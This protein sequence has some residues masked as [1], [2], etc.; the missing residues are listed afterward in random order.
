MAYDLDYWPSCDDFSRESLLRGILAIC[1]KVA[2]LG[3]FRGRD[4]IPCNVNYL[5][6][7]VSQVLRFLSAKIAS[8]SDSLPGRVGMELEL[9]VAIARCRTLQIGQTLLMAVA[10]MK[11]A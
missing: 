11:G 3:L 9:V 10:N 4:T 5:S 2:S 8:C 7:L 1:S 6:G